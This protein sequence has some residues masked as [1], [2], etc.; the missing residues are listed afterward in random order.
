MAF[1]AEYAFP[2]SC[3]NVSEKRLDSSSFKIFLVGLSF[4]LSVS[5]NWY[6]FGQFIKC[7]HVSWFLVRKKNM[8]IYEQL[9]LSTAALRNSRLYL[10][11][12]FTK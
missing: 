8:S 6:Q 10:N 12:V 7:F 5:V 11:D 3:D 9:N 1:M 2:V 4:Q